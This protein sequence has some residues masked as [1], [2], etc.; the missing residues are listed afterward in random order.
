MSWRSS[1][2][3]FKKKACL[4]F[5]I[6]SFERKT[7]TWLITKAMSCFHMEIRWISHEIC[8]IS[9]DPIAG[10]VSPYVFPHS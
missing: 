7:Y 1:S 5:D 8:R 3:N 4:H 6:W 9:K 10:M 2:T